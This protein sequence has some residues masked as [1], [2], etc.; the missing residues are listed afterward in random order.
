MKSYILKVRNRRDREV[1]DI[2]IYQAYFANM[3]PVMWTIEKLI[4]K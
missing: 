1:T 3:S 4:N 2:D